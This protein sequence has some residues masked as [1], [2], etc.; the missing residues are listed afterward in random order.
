MGY[1]NR[2]SDLHPWDI[3]FCDKLEKELLFDLLKLSTTLDIEMLNECCA[4]TVAKNMIGKTVEEMRE[5]LNEENDY[6]IWNY[7]FWQFI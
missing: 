5:Y 2:Y 6:I 7:Y 4:K 3:M 1:R